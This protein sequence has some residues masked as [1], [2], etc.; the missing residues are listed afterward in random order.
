MDGAVRDGVIQEDAIR[1]ADR[2]QSQWHM[3]AL[4]EAAGCLIPRDLHPS[5]DGV[6]PKGNAKPGGTAGGVSVEAGGWGVQ[7]GD[8]RSIVLDGQP[9][10]KGV[11]EFGLILLRS[12]CSV[13]SLDVA[14]GSLGLGAL[15][16][17][18]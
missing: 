18:A 14:V 7:V 13:L 4:M 6:K 16:Y 5:M 8:E 1:V 11:F 3:P 9:L 15:L 2:L 12:V 10:T 17:A